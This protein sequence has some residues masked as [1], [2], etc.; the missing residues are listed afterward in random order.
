MLRARAVVV[1]SVLAWSLLPAAAAAAAEPWQWPLTGQREVSRAFA[2]PATRFGAGHRG[3]DLPGEPGAVV[4]AAG[5]GQVSYAG[6]LAGRGVVVVV[7]GELRTTYEPVTALHPVGTSVA[8]GEPIGR[9][10]AGHLGC[11][12]AACLHWGLKRGEHYLDPT[13]L[14]DRGPVRLL[15]LAVGAGAG[16]PL[17][18]ASD[19]GTTRL[20]PPQD[21]RDG[22]VD[23][24]ATHG[25][26]PGVAEPPW[27]LRAA[28]APLGMAAVAALVL[29]IGLLV[30]P[31][32]LPPAPVSGGM[33]TPA[34]PPAPR[35]DEA[36]GPPATLLDLDE[37][38]ARRQVAS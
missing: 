15:P 16:R 28:E 1:L 6:L 21:V 22:G 33:A 5:S 7:H 12:A 38:R 13:R 37:A 35:Q 32:P 34:A 14:V 11:A 17:N 8:A 18:P 25:P 31:R 27:S 19:A 2:P 36:A 30:R 4:R 29:G 24:P 9:L 10:E 23:L 3:V 20:P 26:P